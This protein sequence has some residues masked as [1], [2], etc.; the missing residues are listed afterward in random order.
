MSLDVA[1]LHAALEKAV[2]GAVRFDRL[3]RA[4]YS[5]DASLYAIPPLGAVLPLDTDDV[6]ATLRVCRAFGASIIPRGAGTGIA[7]GA[8]GAGVQLDFSRHMHGILEIDSDRRLARV[9]P[10]VVL[11]DLNA[12]LAPHGL[13]FAP[14]VATASRATIGGM[15]A[16]NS[17]GSHSVLYRR[18]VDHVESVKCVLASGDVV[19]WRQLP[20]ADLP[21]EA[22]GEGPT[23]PPATNTPDS[24]AIA[25]IDAAMRGVRDEFCA[26]VLRQ[27]PRVMR[28]NGGYA[29]DRLV[30]SSEPNPAT[31]ICGSEGTLALVVE[32]TLRL[33]PL[34]KHKALLIARYDDVFSALGAAPLYLEHRPAAV[35][36][37]NRSILTQGLISAPPAVRALLPEPF[38]A[39]ILIGE[40]YDNDNA[41]LRSRMWALESHLHSARPPGAGP[42]RVVYQPALQREIWNIRNRGFGLLM[43]QPGSTQ[44]HEFI[45]DAAVDPRRLREYIQR[46]DALLAEEDVKEVGYYAHASVGV[47]H[48]RPALNLEAPADVSR[49]RRIAERTVDL[50]REFSGA[51]TGEHGDGLVRSEWLERVYGPRITRAFRE[52]KDAFDPDRI[53][54]PGKIVDAAPMTENLRYAQRTRLIP[55]TR[56]G[57]EPHADMAAMAKMCSGV[58]Q[59]RQKLVGV[60]CPSY[61]ATLDERHTTRARANALRVALS[62]G[63]LI[64]GLNDA[65]LDD[66]MDLCLSCK[67]C[68]RECPTGVDMA[69]LKAEWLAARNEKRGASRAARFIAHMPDR[70]PFASLAPRLANAISQSSIARGFI[71][72][73][74][75]LDR[76]IPPPRFAQQTLRAWF[77]RR[78]PRRNAKSRGLV[79]FFPD[80][81]TNHVQ[82]NVGIAAIH[83]L[84][85]VGF[86]V[87]MPPTVCCGRTRISAGFLDEAAR[88]GRQ[89]VALLTP[90][91]QQGAW[92]VGVEPSCVSALTDDLPALLKSDDAHSLAERVRLVDSLLAA[93][94]RDAPDAI[95]QQTRPAERP[96]HVHGHCHQKALIGMTDTIDLLTALGL[97]AN[98]LDT[99]C[100]GMAGAFGHEK[101]HYDVAR[102]IGEHRLFPAVRER[103]DAEIAVTGFS[104]H[105]QIQH[106]TGVAT[107]HV[108]EIAYEAFARRMGAH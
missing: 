85:A 71:E 89:N 108:L 59:C 37:I 100:C 6:S 96:I 24:A 17:C 67:A 33:T 49:M 75:G 77:K 35:E 64:D 9:Q 78:T 92:I 82:P 97:N 79:A 32:A 83:L 52:I 50:V 26:D 84:E 74:Y 99:G 46:L 65:A 53:L 66:V 34:P 12:A 18:T 54:N 106:H 28:R 42:T 10:G 7:G 105:E 94:L 14:D 5:T 90:F 102:A 3:T 98:A 61:V 27:Y 1:K 29:L 23:W 40:L 16:N 22:T 47:I 36:L 25:R 41:S 11:D 15:I 55:L 44:P 91:I 107:R 69:R 101:S 87:V 19:E 30:M 58:G 43:A 72:R 4:I 63:G 20:F 93:T 39:A 104:C 38:P 70:L 8:V 31:L 88:L 21:P 103:G 73:R 60:M 95:P 62:E 81:F 2:R 80:T 13:H 57:F 76:R 45:E 48:V 56:F 68:K 86:E 51:F